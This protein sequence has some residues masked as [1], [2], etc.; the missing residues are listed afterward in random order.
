MQNS[1]VLDSAAID[2]TKI[3]YER[4]FKGEEVCAAYDLAL[5]S[6]TLLRGP[7]EARIFKLFKKEDQANGF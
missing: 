7:H 4:L 5:Q 2:F 1:K 6:V 3:F